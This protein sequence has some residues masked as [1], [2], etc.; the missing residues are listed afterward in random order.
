M[1]SSTAAGTTAV[2]AQNSRVSKA[3]MTW[4]IFFLSGVF[5]SGWQHNRERKPHS[6]WFILRCCSYRTGFAWLC[7]LS[8]VCVCVCVCL[9]MCVC[10]CLS[11]CLYVCVLECGGRLVLLSWCY[12][13]ALFMS[14]LLCV[15]WLLWHQRAKSFKLL[16]TECRYRLEERGDALFIAL[17]GQISTQK[18]AET[19]L[20]HGHGIF[21]FQFS[22]KSQIEWRVCLPLRGLQVSWI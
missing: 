21:S 18:L 15:F 2:F 19:G 7:W 11:A 22:A 20:H 4:F 9:C 8:C 5:C 10:A 14:P 13:W 6:P 12:I 1:F 17:P 3:L 16:T